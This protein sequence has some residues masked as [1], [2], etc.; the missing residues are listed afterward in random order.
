MPGE[1][2]TIGAILKRTA[3]VV[4]GDRS[5][6]VSLLVI[7]AVFSVAFAVVPGSGWL[8]GLCS[9]VADIYLSLIATICVLER[10]DLTPSQRSPLPSPGRVAAATLLFVLVALPVLIGFLLLIVPGLLLAAMWCLALPVLVAERLQVLQAMQ[11][12]WRLAEPRSDV[13]I[14]LIVLTWLPLL[15]AMLLDWAVLTPLLGQPIGDAVTNIVG[16]ALTIL[17]AALWAV[18]YAACRAEEDAAADLTP[19]ADPRHPRA[20]T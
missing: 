17:G 11:R 9:T 18:A 12:S 4:R 16:A 10:L 20:Y 2:V 6:F 1:I 3:A 5:T 13:V 14:G 19:P 15:V 7:D 8:L